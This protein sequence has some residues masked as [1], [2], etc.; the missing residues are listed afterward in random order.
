VI[1]GPSSATLQTVF[2]KVPQVQE[3]DFIIEL[4]N[5]NPDAEEVLMTMKAE[6]WMARLLAKAGIILC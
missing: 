6:P 4:P 5:S 1:P 2:Y 3:C